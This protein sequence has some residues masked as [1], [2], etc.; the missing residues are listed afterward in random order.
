MFDYM[1]DEDALC[2]TTT[3]RAASA[4]RNILQTVHELSS[5]AWYIEGS[6]DRRIANLILSLHYLIDLAKR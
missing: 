4:K 2:I 1:R 3:T 5:P 6:Q